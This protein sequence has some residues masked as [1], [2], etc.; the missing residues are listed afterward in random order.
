MITRPR[1]IPALVH[2]GPDGRIYD[3]PAVEMAGMNGRDVVPIDPDELIP[4]PEGSDLLTL[5]DRQPIGFPRHGRGRGPR[6]FGDRQAVAAFLAPAYTRFLNPAMAAAP[7]ASLLPLYAYTAV[8]WQDG[9]FWIPATRVDPDPRQDPERFDLAELPRRVAAALRSAPRDNRLIVHL[10][11]CALVRRC[12]AARN[13]FLQRW[14]APLPT[15]PACNARCLGCISEQPGGRTQ[16]FGRIAFRP[17]PRELVEVAVPHLERAP[18]PVV[19]FG[20]G[21]EGEPL[22]VADLLEQAIRLFRQRTGR[23]VINLNTNGSRPAEVARLCAAGLEAIRVSLPAVLPQLF[24]AYTQPA[25]FG[26]AEVLD[27]LRAAREGGARTS[28]NYF[29]FPGVS[30]RQA[31]AEAL[32]DL[33]ASGLVDLIQLRNLNVDP[34]L[35]L[36]ALGPLDAFGCASGVSRLIGQL[37]ARFPRLKLGYFNPWFERPR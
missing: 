3:D 18:R 11:D 2:A 30:D 32:F 27:S 19:S 23:G 10:G 7:G 34:D 4:L 36:D 5:P 9:R 37:R 29:V 21:C 16:T 15:S 13:Y 35:Y 31:E 1:R 8:G 33:C 14:E 22:L 26:R 20:Q 24:A 25:G 28:I 6:T 17:E 12:P